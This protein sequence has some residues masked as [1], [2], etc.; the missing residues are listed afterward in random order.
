MH[1]Q[2]QYDSS[3]A[4]A[5]AGFFTSVQTA[6]ANTEAAIANDF[7]VIMNFGWGTL[8]GAAL[9]P[10]NLGASSTQ[11]FT[12]TYDQVI[13]ALS[14]HLDTLDDKASFAALPA[15][16]PS[17]GNGISVSA[18]QAV[19]LG[20]RSPVQPIV[21]GSV[22][23]NPA[24]PFAFDPGQGVG[25]GQYDAVATLLHEISEVLGRVSR[26][27]SG[28]GRL[29]ILDL[30]RYSA[31][32]V[33][34]TSTSAGWFSADGGNTLVA[35]F[36]NPA[37]GGDAG[38]WADSVAGDAFTEAGSPGA[39]EAITM[40]DLHV[41]DVLGY[42]IATPLV[43]SVY[44]TAGAA[45]FSASPTIYVFFNENV[46]P[47]LGNIVV[48]RASDDSV[49]QTISITDTAHVTISSGLVQVSLPAFL[50]LG[51]SY[52]IT[53]DS[54]A[55]AD[56]FGASFIGLVAGSASAFSTPSASQEVS[57][58]F[59]S[60]L[61]APTSASSLALENQLI[62]DLTQGGSQAASLQSVVQAAGSTSSVAT[63]SYE[64]FTGKAPGAAGM[65]YLVSPTG[66]NPNNLNSAYYAQFSL[67]NRYINF[68]SNL[69]KEGEGK[70]QFLAQYGGLDLSSALTKAYTTIFGSAPS[71]DKVSHLVHDLVPD[72][73]GG[74]YER[75]AYFAF[76]GQDG[77]NGQGTKAAMV[78]WLMAEAVKADVGTYAL[79][80]DA[81][82]N[83]VALHNTS[84]GV[85]LVGVYS[86]SSFIFH[87]T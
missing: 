62:T 39:L 43:S 59:G 3:T 10:G 5:P 11:F 28:T 60:V 24:D 2:I 80:N 71:A 29:S 56:G 4:S 36:N 44:P 61:R 41:M 19:V 85:D 67:T 34:T 40:G 23:L 26:L 57:F 69:G 7:T 84:F 77:L 46:T 37:T 18:A 49:A 48:H 51:S 45:T 1:I 79:S 38:D 13:S 33:H 17:F 16:D 20:L 35:R 76:Y 68:A 64:F 83:D 30:N 58:W 55:V 25:A 6:V 50:D 66:P 53:V 8:N 54:G 70:A 52:Y 74:S 14:T 81:F 21:A 65:D 15:G 22:G 9:D 12:F 42:R 47:R 78:G 63:L 75:A 72:G 31:S 73:V 87:S 27:D 32:G 86:Q 82:L